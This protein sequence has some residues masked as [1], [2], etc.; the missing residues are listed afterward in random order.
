MKVIVSRFIPFR[1]FNA[2]NLFGLIVVRKGR[3][4]GRYTLNHERIHTA[5]MRE[6]AY[7]FFYILYLG[8]W[9]VRLLMRGNAYRNIS[10]E[11]E[12][13][14]HMGDLNYLEH[15]RHYTWLRHYKKKPNK[16]KKMKKITFLLLAMA[17]APFAA[18]AFTRAQAQKT[19]DAFVADTML[20]HASAGVALVDLSTGEIIAG[21]HVDVAC[22]T[23]STMKT[24]TSSAA[25]LTLGPDFQYVT[26]VY[27]DGA[28]KGNRLEGNIVVVGTGDPTLGSQFFK[29]DLDI[30]GEIVKA[31]QSHGI[32]RIEGKV[33][34]DNSAYPFPPYCGDWDVGDLAWNY[35]MG[36]HAVNYCDNLTRLIFDGHDGTLGNAHLMPDVSNVEIIDMLSGRGEDN[37][38]LHLE[39]VHPAIIATGTTIDTTYYMDI[40]NP[41]PDVLL[42]DSI[43]NSLTRAGIAVRWREIDARGERWPLVEHRSPA[44][45]DIVTSLLERSDNMFAEGLLRTLAYHSGRRAT[46]TNGVAVVDSVMRRMGVDVSAKFQ[47]D[48]SGLARANKATPR[49]FAQMLT[50]MNSHKMGTREVQLVDLMPRVGVNARIGSSIAQSPI[51]GQVAT[52]SGSMSDVQCYVGYYPVNAPKWGFVTLINNWRG[53]RRALREKIDSMLLNVF[54]K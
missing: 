29:D 34:V 16:L 41:C 18:N 45:T 32:N 7:L 39:Y 40:A 22:I 25:R 10:F 6:L 31:L 49:F 42:R 46:C 4:A 27:L 44:L 30:T 9:L 26:P 38:D 36:I 24:V 17:L 11:R 5:Q 14:A 23:A 50:A 8:E 1:G 53:S 43:A 54:T 20:R 21:N 13:Y 51:S 52:K 35:G 33:I 28:V 48:G 37:V 47:R 19:V 3:R 2:I 12:A 15:R